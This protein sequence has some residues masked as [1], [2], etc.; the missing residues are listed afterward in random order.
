MARRVGP[1]EHLQLEVE[2]LRRE[3]LELERDLQRC[4]DS[5][6]LDDELRHELRQAQ[7]RRRGFVDSN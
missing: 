1:R 3:R 6:S 5:D 7:Q 4:L 2:R